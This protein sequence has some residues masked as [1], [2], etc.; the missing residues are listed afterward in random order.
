MVNRLQFLSSACTLFA[1]ESQDYSL[2][3]VL[4]ELTKMNEHLT[5]LMKDMKSTILRVKAVEDRMNTSTIASDDSSIATS[6]S[7]ATSRTKTVPLAVRVSASCIHA[8]PVIH[9]RY[10]PVSIPLSCREKPEKCMG[11][12]WKRTMISMDG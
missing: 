1:V 4:E 11:P 6:S 7:K 10:S 9:R 2:V 8:V 12:S 3:H 5:S